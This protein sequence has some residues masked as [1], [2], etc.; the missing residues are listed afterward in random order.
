[1]AGYAASEVSKCSSCAKPKSST[2]DHPANEGESIREKRQY[3]NGYYGSYSNSYSYPQPYSYGTQQRSSCLMQSLLNHKIFCARKKAT[4]HVD[5]A[6]RQSEVE[7]ALDKARTLVSVDLLAAAKAEL[8]Q[9]EVFEKHPELLNEEVVSNAIRRY[10]TCWL[11]MK[12]H[13][14]WTAPL[15]VMLDSSRLAGV[16]V[17]HAYATKNGSDHAQ[18]IHQWHSVCPG[19]PFEWQNVGPVPFYKPQA[20]YDI[21]AA[22]KRQHKFAKKILALHMTS[23]DIHRAAE[24]YMKFLAIAAAYPDLA[25]VPTLEMDVAWHAHQASY[26]EMQ[27]PGG[28]QLH[29]LAYARDTEAITGEFVDHVD[30]IDEDEPVELP[31][32]LFAKHFG[33]AM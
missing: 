3:N 10:E 18:T 33:D 12:P 31:A 16:V 24:E 20:S 2:E 11:P 22:V 30:E 32:D 27:Y 13:A 9:L 6:D 8:R 14:N 21:A 26:F 19:E 15:D 7:K 28:F 29:P 17:D 5:K 4:S 1:M 23:E 25:I